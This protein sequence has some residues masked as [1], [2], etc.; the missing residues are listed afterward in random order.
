MPA[1]RHRHCG[2]SG[3]LDRGREAQPVLVEARVDGDHVREGERAEEVGPRAVVE[4]GRRDARRA[5]RPRR[6]RRR[7]R[8][9]GDCRASAGRCRRSGRSRPRRSTRR[10]PTRYS[11][12][13]RRLPHGCTK[14]T[15]V[16][17]PATN[18][19]SVRGHATY[20][21]PRWRSDVQS[22]PHPGRN[23][24]SRSPATSVID[25]SPFHVPNRSPVCTATGSAWRRPS[26][27][28]RARRA[29]RG[30]ASAPARP[31]RTAPRARPRSI[32]RPCA[33]RGPR[34]AGST[35]PRGHR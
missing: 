22:I 7:T 5:R 14:G 4:A 3:R 23:V 17:L 30:S 21:S 9:R 32:A 24:A 8:R 26:R 6:A 1:E 31:R 12:P 18:C 11:R 29:P 28:P 35:P 10:R 27:P 20:W 16:T 2:A 33:S 19:G 15:A 25:G 34:R 13:S